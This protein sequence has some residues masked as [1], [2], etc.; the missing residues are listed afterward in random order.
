MVIKKKIIYKKQ[1][2]GITAIDRIM[3]P[4]FDIINKLICIC[5]IIINTVVITNANGNKLDEIDRIIE[6]LN[7]FINKNIKYS[8]FINMIT[9]INKC[10]Q[11]IQNIHN[12]QDIKI[13]IKNILEIIIESLLS[14]FIQNLKF[15]Y[16]FLKIY[17]HIL[18]IEYLF[19]PNNSV[20]KGFVK[21]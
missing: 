17:I 21:F 9:N 7:I 4:F 14:N 15:I 16:K 3:I 10:I 11:T 6:E 12:I 20:F 18:F 5:S 19:N 13:I 2:G 1:K 8:L